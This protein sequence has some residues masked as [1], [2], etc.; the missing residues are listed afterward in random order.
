MKIFEFSLSHMRDYKVRLLDEEKAPCS[1]SKASV[2]PSRT[3]SAG[4]TANSPSFPWNW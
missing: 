3:T 2:T 4:W 1:G